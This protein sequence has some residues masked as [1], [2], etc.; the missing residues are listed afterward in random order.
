MLHEKG[1][2]LIIAGAGAGK[3]KTITHRIAHLIAGGTPAR[4]I[5]AVTFTNKAAG[6][7]RERIRNLLKGGEMPFVSTF[8]SL[9]VRLLREFAD[10]AK[11]PRHFV[12]WDRD[13]SIR[14]IKTILKERGL[15]DTFNPRAILS[16]I[17]KEKADVGEPESYASSA[18]THFER[19]TAD[20]WNAYETMKASEKAL[21]FDDLL[22]RT[23]LLL[24]KNADVLSLLQDRWTHITI[25][26]YQ[27]TNRPQYEIARLL[28]GE[29]M[30]I[31][32]VG[33]VDQCLTGD[34]QV[35]MADGKKKRIDNVTKGD[36][37][38]SNYGGGTMRSALVTKSFTRNFSGELIAIT[39]ASGKVITSTPEHI[40]FAGYRLG[41]VPQNFFTYLMYKREVG[42]RLGVSQ[43]YT[44]GQR[45]RV[46]GFIQ[47]CNQEH[48][49]AVWILATHASVSEARVLEYS[50]SL[51]YAIPTLPFVARKGG[52]TG[53]YVHDQSIIDK[54]FGS[55][56]TEK[57]ANSLFKTFG[58][59]RAYPHH[60]PR[61]KNSNRR[62]V[63]IALC[64]ECRGNTP[65]HRISMVGNDIEGKRLL[66]S[67]EFSVRPAKRDS[68]SW[69]FETCYRNYA[70]VRAAVDRIRTVFPDA[71]VIETARL[72][73]K[74]VRPKDGNSLPFLPA[75][76]VLPGMALFANDSGYEIVA[77][78]ERKKVENVPV[79]DIN[80]ENT[81]NFIANGILTHNCIYA[82]RQARIEN[83]LSFE[84]SFPGTKSVLLEQNYRST[85]TILTAANAVIRKNSNRFE[86]NLFTENP[87]GEAIELYAAGD[88]RSEAR[89]VVG[90]ARELIASGTDPSEIAVLYRENFLSRALEEA[91]IEIGLPYRVLGT[92]FFERS[93]VKDLL[94]YVRAALNPESQSDIARIIA[95]P[96]RG[97]GKQTAEKMFKGEESS[98]TAAAR[99]KIASFRHLLHRMRE[100]VQAAR[101]SEALHFALVE[102]GLEKSF[103][104]G[105]EEDHERLANARELVSLATKYDALPAPEGIERLLEDAALMSE[106]DSLDPSF[107]GE[108][109]GAGAIS[110]MTVHASKGL[111][112]DAVFVTGLEQ[113]LF[114]SVRDTETRDPEEERRLF[115][116]ALT[117]ARNYLFLTYALSRLKYGSREYG[118]PS[119]FLEDI[120]PRL[121]KSA[122][123]F[124]NVIR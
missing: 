70:N 27:D 68:P 11:L 105:D 34:T 109:T 121:L 119:E 93:E 10:S 44:N 78:V 55:F 115:Y 100:K 59:S 110:L 6:E 49:D 42:Y 123:T 102:S 51:K 67:V 73:G 94:S 117:R 19:V 36:W 4:H 5:L 13:D 30:N 24:Q 80:V 32:A 71:I 62:N 74:K 16:A 116:V 81:H 20:V 37:I 14:A 76:S 63:V 107:S 108:K 99:N 17:S 90:R 79:Y 61:S 46:V 56:D 95:S 48:G 69:R 23:L 101:A 33:D 40:H 82:W 60:R 52:G 89:F 66:E 92:R 118:M 50:L 3:T 12:I 31:C 77:R 47:R 111:E 22:L 26:E 29:A 72:G 21:D 85:Q 120:D 15:G 43:V 39:T 9:G 104:A 38:L 83:L 86:K 98:L 106:Q 124:E 41:I 8:H 84:K 64:G 91:C 103:L 2:L 65:M 114:P 88:E 87:T 75:A 113:G 54:I 7:M 122:D 96:P 97:I 58:L 57:A 35:T 18:R 112:F 53:G 1:P 28:A 45:K 25:D